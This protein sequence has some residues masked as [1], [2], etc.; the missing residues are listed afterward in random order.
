MKSF[1]TVLNGVITGKH[2]GDINNDLYGS[3]YFGHEK[4]EVPFDA[5]TIPLEP[6][7]FYTSDWKRKSNEQLI[8]EK[9]LPM[10]QGHVWEGEELRQMTNEERILEGLDNP[11]QGYKVENGK[12]IQMTLFERLDAGQISQT[13]YNQ[14]MTVINSN[15]LNNRL[16]EWQTPES[17]ALAD[18]SEEYAEER[19]ANMKALLAVKNQPGWPVD[20]EWA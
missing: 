19:K 9:L 8:K 7:T 17:L 1:I 6:L 5:Q 16:S 2:H 3:P 12:I 10:P 4:I 14:Q 15:E 11:Q 20:V 18:L 13:E